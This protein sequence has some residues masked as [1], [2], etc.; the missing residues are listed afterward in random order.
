MMITMICMNT[1]KAPEQIDCNLG[2][3]F[4]AV[5]DQGNYDRTYKSDCLEFG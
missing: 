5:A 3:Q 1:G 4:I 2:R